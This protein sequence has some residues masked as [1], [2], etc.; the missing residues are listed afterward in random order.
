MVKVRTAHKDG[1]TAKFVAGR[2]TVTHDGM[3][4]PIAMGDSH[5]DT[6][7]EIMQA[8]EAILEEY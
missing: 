7:P 3:T 2:F 4:E 6:D 5:P 8:L 1:V